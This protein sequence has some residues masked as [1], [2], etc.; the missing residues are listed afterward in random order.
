MHVHLRQHLHA[1]QRNT[2]SALMLY[3]LLVLRCEGIGVGIGGLM[4]SFDRP[5]ST[6][7]TMICTAWFARLCEWCQCN[8]DA[9]RLLMMLCTHDLA[10]IQQGFAAFT[11]MQYGY[12]LHVFGR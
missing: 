6:A 8:T 11:T 5:A 10:A 7:A 4:S 2:L 1:L 3:I 12:D 9:A